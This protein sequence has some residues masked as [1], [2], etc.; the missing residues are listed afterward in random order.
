M[1][2]HGFTLI[3]L[4]IVVAII[5]ILAA[6]AVPNFLEAQVRSKV[7]R[8]RSDQR[9]LATALETY[10]V[11]NNN[12]Y[13]SDAGMGQTRGAGAGGGVYRA[14]A[15]GAHSADPHANWSIGFELTTP[16]AYLTSV[17]CM[18]D[19]FKTT[20]LAKYEADPNLSGRMYYNYCNWPLA[21]WSAGPGA[22]TFNGKMDMMGAWVIIG[23]GPDKFVNNGKIGGTAYKDWG[24][25]NSTAYGVNYDPTNGTV[26]CGDVY[27]S[28]KLPSS[29]PENAAVQPL[30]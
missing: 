13:P 22:T 14:Y 12:K 24:Y 7:S 11:D 29:I 6:I 25:L 27:R 21:N 23:A 3:E 10:A 30:P 8:C 20:D 26:S 4:L 19:P 17:A 15:G 2:K 28:Q 18:I 16:I 1:K 5:A 9:T